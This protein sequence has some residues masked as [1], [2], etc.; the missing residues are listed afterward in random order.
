MNKHKI[1]LMSIGVLIIPIGLALL[2]GDW[3]ELRQVK[4]NGT[5]LYGLRI[6]FC[7]NLLLFAMLCYIFRM[8]AQLGASARSDN[9]SEVESGLSDL[10]CITIS[11]LFPLCIILLIYLGI[12]AK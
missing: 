5:A 9:V 8:I 1:L 11:L 4:S 3:V 6:S 2:P 12:L 10:M 7:I